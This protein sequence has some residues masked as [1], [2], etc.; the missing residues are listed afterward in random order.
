MPWSKILPHQLDWPVQRASFPSTVSSTMKP[1]PATMPDQ[2]HAFMNRK[3][4]ATHSAAP[5]SV[6]WL[7]VIPARAA[8]R[9]RW[10][11]SRRHR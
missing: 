9:V 2:Y 3:K 11:A 10:K 6:I 7:G 5:I 4:V 8:Q 1:K